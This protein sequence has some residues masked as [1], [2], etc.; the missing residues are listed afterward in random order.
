MKIKKLIFFCAIIAVAAAL[1]RA[2]D[3]DLIWVT[4]TNPQGNCGLT[5]NPLTDQIYYL[6]NHNPDLIQIVSSDSLI[7]PIGTIPTPDSGC[8]DLKF[9]NY[10]STFWVLSNTTKRVYKIDKVGIVKRYFDSPANE[11]PA[12]LAWDEM[13][14]QLYI[15]DCRTPG[16]SPQYIYVTD[17]LGNLLRRMDHPRSAYLGTKCL[18]FRP[19]AA[20]EG[21]YLL[22]VVTYEDTIPYLHQDSV[23]IYALDTATGVEL[24]SF[25]YCHPVMDSSNCRGIEYDPRTNDYW[26]GL[27]LHGT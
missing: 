17:T 7:T 14:R 5:Y 22:N 12:G 19:Q 4:E 16:V 18:A 21:P 27:F 9:C 24:A 20:G 2:A 15:S 25:P 1:G 10:D 23:I 26:I 6:N 11:S 13:G 3:G 8:V